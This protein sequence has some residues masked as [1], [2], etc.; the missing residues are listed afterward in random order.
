MRRG[1]S[2]AELDRRR[3]RVLGELAARGAHGLCLFSPANVL[4]LT[5]WASF[6]SERPVMFALSADGRSRLLV[7]VMEEERATPGA[8]VDGVVAY[9]EYPGKRHPMSYATD[10]LRGMGI[11]RGPLAVDQPGP[12]RG[13]GYRGPSLPSLL[14]DVELLPAGP[15]LEALMVVK[16]DEEIAFLR[17]SA[18]WEERALRLLQE[19]SR[20]GLT[21]TEISLAASSK[22]T[23]EMMDRFADGGEVTS[24]SW[25]YMGIYVGFRGQVGPGSALPH[26][27]AS[28]ARLRAGDVLGSG[29]AASVA[30]YTA[31]LERTMIVGTSTREQR[32]LF[33]HML[34]LQEIAIQ[35]IGPGVPCAR[36]D[37]KVTAYYAQQGLTE[38]WRHHTGHGLGRGDHE[39]P[40]LDVGDETELVP[41][42]VVS[43]EPGLYV[44]GLG[45][46]RHSD[47]VLVTDEG[48]EVLTDY[49]RELDAL[50]VW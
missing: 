21:E 3:E 46:F 43:V 49:P 14:P 33:E 42:M 44:P 30:G 38:L 45:G 48:H 24:L 34:A 20:E 25:A 29:A 32:R 10:L 28:H 17:E 2:R 1:V 8:L 11:D 18:R 47:T 13:F 35:A 9:P 22:A 36:V 40:F 19:G 12:G 6:P 50:I 31:E 7:P 26:A 15:F 4:Y 16:S 41:G 23:L 27:M 37:E 39:A 5:G